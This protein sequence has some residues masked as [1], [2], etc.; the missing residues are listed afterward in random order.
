M[1][2]QSF[3][4]L[5]ARI[6]TIFDKKIPHFNVSRL[7]R[8]FL[9]LS[10]LVGSPRLTLADYGFAVFD[11]LSGPLLGSQRRFRADAFYPGL[12]HSKYLFGGWIIASNQ[13]H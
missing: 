13:F 5:F 8:M 10:R 1:H 7:K 2:F 3:F 6:L 11:Q 4:Q 9:S 12:T